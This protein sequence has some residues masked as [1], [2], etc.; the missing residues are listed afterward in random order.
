MKANCGSQSEN[1]NRSTGFAG[2][3]RRTNRFGIPGPTGRRLVPAYIVITAA[4]LLLCRPIEATAADGEGKSARRVVTDKSAGVVK[5]TGGLTAASAV[6]RTQSPTSPKQSSALPTNPQNSSSSAGRSDTCPGT[7]LGALSSLGG[8]WAGSTTASTDDFDASVLGCADLAGGRDEIFQFTVS[9]DGIWSFDTCTVAAGWDTT[10]SLH[11]NVGAGCPGEFIACDGD[12]CN[13]VYY[14][15][16]RSALL[17]MGPTYYLIVDGWSSAAYGD[18][19]VTYQY[20]GAVPTG[21]PGTDVGVLS[22][23]GGSWVGSTDNSTDDFDDGLVHCM[24]N[25]GGPDEIFQFTVETAG[26]WTFDT[27]TVPACWDTVLSLRKETGGGC[28]GDFVACNDDDED[29]LCAALCYYESALESFVE[30]GTTYYLIVDGWSTF[31][32]GDFEVTYA[33]PVSGCIDDTQCDDGVFCNGAEFCDTVSGFCFFGDLPC[34]SIVDCDEIKMTCGEPDPCITWRAG[35]ASAF[36]FPQANNCPNTETWVFD[37]IQ[38]THLAGDVLDSYTT[39]LFSD[40]AVPGASLDGTPFF[41]EQAI[42]TV[43]LDTCNPLT[44]LSGTQCTTNGVV[45][46]GLEALP[47]SGTMPVLPNNSGDFDRCEVDFFI[48]FRT[49]ENGAGMSIA[50]AE[51]SIGGPGAADDF[52]VNVI[53]VEGCPDNGGTLGVFTPTFFGDDVNLPADF[54]TAEVC[55]KPGD[56]CGMADLTGAVFADDNGVPQNPFDQPGNCAIDAREPHSIANVAARNGWDRMVLSFSCDPTSLGLTTGDFSVS[57]TPPNG[58][59]GIGDVNVDD[60][61][62]TVTVTLTDKILP[63]G[64]TCIS[65]PASAGEWCMGYLPADASQ[66]GLSAPSDINALINAINLVP[67]FEQPLYAS[68][69]DRSGLLLGSDILRLIDLLNGAGDFDLWIT[70]KLPPCPSE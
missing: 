57:T 30:G 23:A 20:L 12:G 70:A 22:N 43:E 27:C 9:A 33:N 2:R 66:D 41:V 63:G 54:G 26:I 19:T 39:P 48:A 60:V 65:H 29:G 67:G 46:A 37:D 68:D 58:V 21:C 64:W 3:S 40:S 31:A 38:V 8:A 1:R 15:S 32:Y 35:R 62:N 59:L 24:A 61:A 16:A 6:Q 52:G 53:W 4:V 49:A 51:E 17:A 42:W 18:F 28:P 44:I 14:E 13:V 55:Q 36:F 25:P 5:I 69:M 50:G 45:G 56:G 10:L 34:P 47:C 11:E 7:D